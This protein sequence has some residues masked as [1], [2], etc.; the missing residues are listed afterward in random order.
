[1]LAEYLETLSKC[2]RPQQPETIRLAALQS[3]Q[4]FS[5]VLATAF[6]SMSPPSSVVPAALSLLLLLSDDDYNIRH[7]ASEITSAVLGDF[8]VS[9]PMAAS[10]M[11]TRAIGET[12]DP[13]CIEMNVIP[14][15]CETNVHEALETAM[16]SSVTLFAKGRENVWRD[17]IHQ[18]ELYIHMLS[19]C[20]SRWMCTESVLEEST[21]LS[22]VENGFS[23]IKEVTEDRDDVLLGW[24][25]DTEAFEAVMKVFMAV[26]ALQRYGHGKRVKMHARALQGIMAKLHGYEMWKE[27]LS[28]VLGDRMA[29]PRSVHASETPDLS[30]L[31][32]DG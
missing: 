14:L 7:I 13:R 32:L 10:D 21:L 19:S 6:K 25:S 16:G 28:E 20:W 26:E 24:S 18:F 17:E 9:T 3:L 4:T 2:I 31:Q 23:E 27:K 11:L 22:W 30:L 12:F 8:M 5:P 1:V 15:I 29:V